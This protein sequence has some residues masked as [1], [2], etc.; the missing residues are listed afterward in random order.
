[1]VAAVVDAELPDTRL[2]ATCAFTVYWRSSQIIEANHTSFL[3]S[4]HP[5]GLRISHK[6]D[7]HAI[8]FA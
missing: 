4:S 8:R 1:M 7:D 3:T 6:L 5:E 2:R